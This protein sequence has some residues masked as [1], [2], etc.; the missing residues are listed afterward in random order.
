MQLPQLFARQQ[1]TEL[2]RQISVQ[3]FLS[4]GASSTFTKGRSER[5]QHEKSLPF[6]V[7]NFRLHLIIHCTSRMNKGGWTAARVGSWFKFR[8]ASSVLQPWKKSEL[9][10]R[11]EKKQHPKKFRVLNNFINFPTYSVSTS[12]SDNLNINL[13]G[14]KTRKILYLNVLL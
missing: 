4:L 5:R 11:L 14:C 2:S 13:C 12:P 3:I 8:F 7:Y 6:A 9:C 10:N 1:T